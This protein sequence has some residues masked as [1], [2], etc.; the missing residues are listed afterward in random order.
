MRD[1]SIDYCTAIICLSRAFQ[2]ETTAVT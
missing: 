2:I 1:N